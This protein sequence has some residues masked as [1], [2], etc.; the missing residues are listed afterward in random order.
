MDAAPTRLRYFLRSTRTPGSCYGDCAAR[1]SAPTTR[2]MRTTSAVCTRPRRSN[3][4]SKLW[5]STTPRPTSTNGKRHSGRRAAYVTWRHPHR[6]TSPLSRD[7]VHSTW[8]HPYHAKAVWNSDPFRWFPV[9]HFGFLNSEKWPFDA[10]FNAWMR[11][12]R[13][14]RGKKSFTAVDRLFKKSQMQIAVACSCPLLCASAAAGEY[15]QSGF[16]LTWCFEIT[17]Q[18]TG[19]SI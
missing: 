7:A 11:A 1:T 17:F 18:A 3:T 8:P 13:R 10:E 9:R 4:P 19:V 14:Q 2:A 12:T 6:V 15:W 5:S 16:L